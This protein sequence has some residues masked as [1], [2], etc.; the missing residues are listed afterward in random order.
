LAIRRELGDRLGIAAGLNNLGNVALFQ[1]DLASARA[2]YGESLAI[3]RELAQPVGIANSLSNLGEVATEQ[4]D[5]PAA[6]TLFAESL[7]IRQ[8]LGDKRGIAESLEG[9]A[10]LLAGLG[11]SLCAACIWGAAERQREEIGSP[12]PAN[13]WPRHNRRVA[14]AR[15]AL[16]EDAAFDGAWHEGRALTVEQAIG[17]ALEKTVE[18][19]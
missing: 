1:S 11:K 4:G 2:L 16:S 7:A 15:A 14:S 13:E 17:L 10:A 3:K 18:P 5:Y 8:E 6:R 12:L 9:L 19:R